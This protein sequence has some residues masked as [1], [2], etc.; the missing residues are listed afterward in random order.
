ILCDG[1]EILP[2]HMGLR[3][4]ARTA[5]E[6]VSAGGS[7]Q[8]ASSAASRA[9]EARMIEKVLRETGGNKTKAAEILQVSYKTLLT[10]IK[11][12]GLDKE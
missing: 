10:K 6:D 3:A 7:L 12:Y 1:R 2:E 9:V 8:E 5:A 4:Q 11:D